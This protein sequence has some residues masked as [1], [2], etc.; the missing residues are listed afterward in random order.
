MGVESAIVEE[1]VARADFGQVNAARVRNVIARIP[2]TESTGAVLLMSHFNSVPTSPSAND[3]GL[4]VVT[5]LETV[6]AIRAGQP[7]RN[8][9]ILWFGDADETTAM[10]AYALT[11]HPWF[12]DVELALAF[13]GIGMRGPSL[14]SFAGAGNPTA[15]LP[16]QPVGGNAGVENVDSSFTTHNGW[17]LREALRVLPNDDQSARWQGRLHG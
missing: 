15:P 2:G 4:G 8:D 10:N 6:R 12:A 16:A 11:Q 13:E 14:L 5:T 9:V 3:G 17:W 1:V 7:L